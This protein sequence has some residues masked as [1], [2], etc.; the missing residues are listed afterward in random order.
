MAMQGKTSRKGRFKMRVDNAC[1]RNANIR[2]GSE[3]DDG[4]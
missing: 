3:P 2:P 1:T 4:E